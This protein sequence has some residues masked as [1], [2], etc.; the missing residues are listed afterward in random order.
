MGGFE[1][2]GGVLMLDLFLINSV[3]V[4]RVFHYLGLGVV[5]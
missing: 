1:V 4:V 2:V 3:D 5:F